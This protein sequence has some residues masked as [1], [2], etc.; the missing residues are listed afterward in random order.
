MT[1]TKDDW[2]KLYKEV[3]KNQEQGVKNDIR[4]ARKAAKLAIIGDELYKRGHWTQLL[5]CL[6]QEQTEYII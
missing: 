4:I 1:I 5:K 6:S 2:I 3:I